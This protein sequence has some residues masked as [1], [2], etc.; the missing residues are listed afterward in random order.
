MCIKFH[1]QPYA[2]PLYSECLD[3]LQSRVTFA[4]VLAK[5][6]EMQGR[7]HVS[8]HRN[9]FKYPLRHMVR[10]ANAIAGHHERAL[11]LAPNPDA[12]RR[13]TGYGGHT[14]L[15]LPGRQYWS[16][17]D[18]A[19]RRCHHTTSVFPLLCVDCD[20]ITPD[21]VSVGDFWRREIPRGLVEA[22]QD[23]SGELYLGS[24]VVTA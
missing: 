22:I 14:L 2:L 24:T 17:G 9:G 11:H 12:A 15:T 4:P 20:G 7:T 23:V 1:D 5:R 6:V 21:L 18:G 10:D 19:A 13:L 3:G 16:V 8:S